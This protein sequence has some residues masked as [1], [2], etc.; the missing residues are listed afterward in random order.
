MKTYSKIS[1]GRFTFIVLI[2][3]VIY[4]LLVGMIYWVYWKPEPY[5]KYKGVDVKLLIMLA[6]SSDPT[7]RCE[8]AYGE[9]R[10]EILVKLS[11]DPAVCVRRELANCHTLPPEIYRKL[12]N[13]SDPYVR[14]NIAKNSSTSSEILTALLTD[15]SIMVQAANPKTSSDVLATLIYS[16]D[17]DVHYELA[18]NRNT[19]P[20]TLAKLDYENN[21]LIRLALTENPNTPAELL[22]KFAYY[23]DCTPMKN[24]GIHFIDG[25]EV[26]LKAGYY[27]NS[28]LK[29]QAVAN[30]NFPIKILRELADA[31]NRYVRVGIARN[32]NTPIEILRKLS[33]DEDEFVR[34]AVTYHPNTPI[35]DL[36]KLRNDQD[37][38]VAISARESL[39]KRTCKKYLLIFG[40]VFIFIVMALWFWNKKVL[41]LRF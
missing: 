38:E 12:A 39:K 6:H 4:W 26:R 15:E 13:D 31:E 29:L 37:K 18:K 20:E 21:R 25:E 5:F 40:V 10:V 41:S 7:E 23:E 11:D 24:P 34:L 14:R 8:A 32:V 19:P 22:I 35:D 1:F 17:E 3:G 36:I 27:D 2:G 33:R 16:R 30:P 28:T 9:S